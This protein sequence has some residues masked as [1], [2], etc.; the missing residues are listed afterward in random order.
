MMTWTTVLADALVTIH[1]AFPSAYTYPLASLLLPLPS[2][3]PSILHSSPSPASNSYTHFSPPPPLTAALTAPSLLL[4]LFALLAAA[5]ALLRLACFRALGPLFTFELTIHPAHTLVTTGPYAH[6]RHPSYTGVFATLVGATG[7]MLAPGAWLR[8]AWLAPSLSHAA[9]W[10]IWLLSASATAAAASSPSSSGV[11]SAWAPA[12][13][14]DAHGH[15]DVQG[16]I[17]V[18]ALGALLAWAWVAF[19]LAKVAYAGRSTMRRVLTE[20]H[21]LHRVFGPV[22]EEWAARVRWRLLPGVY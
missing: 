2:S 16:A 15:G 8:E 14:W 5:G 20:D 17:R 13:E 3:A 10:V 12:G 1:L 21:E 11:S 19:W 9:R 7:V 18:P 4:L 6:V 22:W